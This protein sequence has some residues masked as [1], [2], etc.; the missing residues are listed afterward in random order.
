MVLRV[1]ARLLQTQHA[2]ADAACWDPGTRDQAAQAGR[3]GRYQ[4][5]DSQKARW[6]RRINAAS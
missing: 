5:R 6:D 1:S 3:L 4:S 2:G